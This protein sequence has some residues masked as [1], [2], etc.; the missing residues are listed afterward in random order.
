[1]ASVKWRELIRQERLSFRY[2][3]AVVAEGIVLVAKMGA[4]VAAATGVPVLKIVFYREKKVL[5]VNKSFLASFMLIWWLVSFNTEA[6]WV[7]NNLL[8]LQETL[9]NSTFAFKITWQKKP[10]DNKAESAWLLFIIIYL[11]HGMEL[12][13]LCSY[14][15][16][17]WEGNSGCRVPWLCRALNTDRRRRWVLLNC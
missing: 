8:A 1:M 16:V 5:H 6:A 15:W 11:S 9:F 10:E 7:L 12:L 17:G 13:F 2:S 3:P 14:G 4:T